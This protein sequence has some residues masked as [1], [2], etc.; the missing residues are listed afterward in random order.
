[1]D[2][3]HKKIGRWLPNWLEGG[4]RKR[5]SFGVVTKQEAEIALLTAPKLG[6]VRCAVMPKA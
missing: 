5:Y 4:K 6:P 1:M 3:F 2:T